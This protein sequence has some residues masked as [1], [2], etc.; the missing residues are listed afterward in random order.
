MKEKMIFELKDFIDMKS[1]ETEYLALKNN[2][3]KT[4][5]ILN[6]AAVKNNNVI[7]S[8]QAKW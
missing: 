1:H 2:C 4:I 8:Q 6:V 3:L 7:D 5:E